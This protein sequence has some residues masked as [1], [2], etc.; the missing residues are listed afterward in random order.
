MP[1]PAGL[2][3]E[4][5]CVAWE[6]GLLDPQRVVAGDGMPIQVVYSGR[7]C[8]D[9]GPDFR[10]AV[11]ALPD[12]TLLYGD[13]EVHSS[14]AG[15]REHGHDSN[16]AYDR[17]VLHVTW[18]DPDEVTTSSGR[19]VRGL[20]LSD[21][22]NLALTELLRLPLRPRLVWGPTCPAA[23]TGRA[24]PDLE[25]FLVEQ[26]R[27]R[28]EARAAVLSAEIDAFGPEQAL[29]TALLRALG[30]RRNTAP[31]DQLSRI[32]PWQSAATVAR[33]AGQSATTALLLGAAGFLAAVQRTLPPADEAL[34][35]R[36]EAMWRKLQ[37]YCAATPLDRGAWTVAGVRPDNAPARRVAAAAA[38]A[39]AHRDGLAAALCSGVDD[40]D[41]PLLQPL[42]DDGYWGAHADLGRLVGPAPA[43]LVGRTRQ[44]EMEV[45]AIL[46]V[47]LALARERGDAALTQA[48][49]TRY[50]A[51]SASGGNQIT[52]HML[53]TIGAPARTA[54]SA[55]AEQGLLHLYTQWCRERRCWHCPIPATFGQPS[56]ST[57][58]TGESPSDLAL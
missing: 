47:A 5:L 13:I 38:L 52:R 9:P 56:G 44:T 11:L 37:P 4:H 19:R 15:W 25:R 1:L 27:A 22:L 57:G 26:G 55:A 8:G 36:W 17:I 28:L 14:W 40:L 51:A 46:P 21:C 35:R 43:A 16:P 7:R 20:A 6:R 12:A 2:R 10:D 39:L 58:P 53:Q 33:I 30:Y 24:A 34:R 18:A 23:V 31:F 48:V 54:R 42:P 3:E 50:A 29:W 45:N 32:V 49:L 41:R